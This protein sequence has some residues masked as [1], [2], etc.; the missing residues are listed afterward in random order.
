MNLLEKA[1]EYTRQELTK[2]Y[3]GKAVS[4]EE[5]LDDIQDCMEQYGEDNDMPEGWWMSYGDI[6]DIFVML[7]EY[8]N[9]MFVTPQQKPTFRSIISIASNWRIDALTL[10][11]AL[12]LLLAMAD[13]DNF[14]LLCVTKIVAVILGYVTNKL[15][16]SWDKEGYLKELEVF[17]DNEE[18][19]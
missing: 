11:F 15:S 10:M 1:L 5:I 8:V 9:N 18:E 6:H 3:R 16:K 13:V 14:L 4:E 2:K 12:T 7:Q 19:E 17:N